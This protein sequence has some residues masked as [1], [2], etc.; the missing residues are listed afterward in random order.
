MGEE[1]GLPSL[2]EGEVVTSAR[3]RGSFSLQGE[4]LLLFPGTG[5]RHR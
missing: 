2:A 5:D 1:G 4:T 3:P